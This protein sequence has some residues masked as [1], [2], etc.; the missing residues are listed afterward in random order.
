MPLTAGQRTHF[1]TAGIQ[2]RLTDDQ[3]QTP[4]TEGLVMESDFIDFKS[5]EL[6]DAFKNMRTGVPGV[7]GIPAVPEVV[8][9]AGNVVQAAIPAY[10]PIP[11]IRA[12]PIH[13]KCASRILVAS[14]AWNYY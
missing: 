4:A 2:M 13:A 9:D 3:R 11:G 10:P 1:F 7:P 8:D 14:I 5:S 12:T 6:K